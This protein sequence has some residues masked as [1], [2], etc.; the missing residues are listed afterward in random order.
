M[1]TQALAVGGGRTLHDVVLG[2]SREGSL[3]RANVDA[4]ELNGYVEYNTAQAGRLHARLARLKIARVADG[5]VV[6]SAI[7]EIVAEHGPDAAEPVRAYI[8]SLASA[9]RQA[10]KDPA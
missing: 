7:V 3:W 4:A 8:E 5:V 6:G 9:V 2:G 1:R 10:A